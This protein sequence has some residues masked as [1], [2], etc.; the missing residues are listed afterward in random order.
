[1]FTYAPKLVQQ[2]AAPPPVN[3]RT[4]S[5]IPLSAPRSRTSSLHP[6]PTPTTPLSI[7]T[8]QNQT[9]LP[10][11]TPAPRRSPEPWVDALKEDVEAEFS[12]FL[13]DDIKAEKDAA[14]AAATTP[15]QRVTIQREYNESMADIRAQARAEFQR[16]VEAERERR[17]LS[18]FH[19][20]DALISEQQNIMESIVRENLRKEASQQPLASSPPRSQTPIQAQPQPQSHF[21]QLSQPI[22]IPAQR[23]SSRNGAPF[24]SV[25]GR[26][27]S[28]GNT[29]FASSSSS[30]SSRPFPTQQIS[31]RP[32][33]PPA[34][35]PA[36]SISSSSISSSVSSVSELSSSHGSSYMRNAEMD[37]Q[38][39]E[40]RAAVQ[41]REEEVRRKEAIARRRAEEARLRE[42]AAA[43][44]EEDARRKIEEAARRI[45]EAELR[46]QQVRAW[47]ARARKEMG[48]VQ[49]EAEAARIRSHSHVE[50]A[51]AT[52]PRIT[53]VFSKEAWQQQRLGSGVPIA[54]TTTMNTPTV[55]RGEVKY[56][57]L[58][59]DRHSGFKQD[60]VSI[61]PFDPFVRSF[62]RPSV[63]PSVV[64]V[65]S[66]IAKMAGRESW[67]TSSSCARRF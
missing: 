30:S 56:R 8:P 23:S 27:V 51:A 57:T 18:H 25:G 35:S 16:R 42:E 61:H 22:P 36:T 29:Q 33:L 37:R 39:E 60:T 12:L 64:V 2:R 45:R 47:E 17:L 52:G 10:L 3:E 53:K 58:G 55:H 31:S 13:V 32:L 34:A 44:H 1:M 67:F 28:F 54:A 50:I 62:V 20:K 9:P 49:K 38:Y 7:P 24:G 48:L 43:R 65:A 26:S 63:R 6:S 59:R 4:S 40:H 11:T 5:Q 21:S 41:R 46:E 19:G 66:V 14:L 15:E